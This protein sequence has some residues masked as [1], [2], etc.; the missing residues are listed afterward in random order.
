MSTEQNKARTHY[1]F[2]HEFNQRNTGVAAEVIAE[3]YV[4]HSAIPAPGPGPEGFKKRAEM[5][6]VAL[7]PHMTF[8]D[9]IAEGDLVSFTW[10]MSGTHQGVF[11]GV[12]PTGKPVT[13][14]G[15]N[16]ERF[17][18]GKIVEHWSQFDLAG[19]LRQ[20]GALPAPGQAQK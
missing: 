2:D 3:A 10:T 17:V 19:A 7:D 15:I 20:I 5:L 16:V 18:E 8:G 4:D 9:F 6:I 13:V 12:P 11:A 1:L 14:N